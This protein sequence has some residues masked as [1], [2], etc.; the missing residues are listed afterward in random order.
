M[1]QSVMRKAGMEATAANALMF[2]EWALR[3]LGTGAPGLAVLAEQ[4]DGRENRRER[5][6]ETGHDRPR[7]IVRARA[8]CGPTGDR[9]RGDG[10]TRS[11][12]TVR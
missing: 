10:G 3:L 4:S 5:A 1:V 12:A 11:D 8:I 7:C 2:M 6:A 9:H